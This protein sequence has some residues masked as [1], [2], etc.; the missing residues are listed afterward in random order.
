MNA[1]RLPQSNNSSRPQA[2]QP[3]AAQLI[4]LNDMLPPQRDGIEHRWCL[5][6]NIDPVLLDANTCVQQAQSAA[7][8]VPVLCSPQFLE[9]EGDVHTL[10]DRMPSFLD[11]M[12]F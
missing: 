5:E 10:P 1:S 9:M 8:H 11:S 3:A 6:G 7:E 12:L 2:D 4:S